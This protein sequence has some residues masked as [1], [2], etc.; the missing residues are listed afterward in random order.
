MFFLRKIAHDGFLWL[1][2]YTTFCGLKKFISA[3]ENFENHKLPTKIHF[4]LSKTVVSILEKM[5]ISYKN[6]GPD[7]V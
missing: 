1:W 2:G 4:V 5:V 3:K 7:D 6:G